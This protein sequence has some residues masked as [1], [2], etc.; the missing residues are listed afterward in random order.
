MKWPP[1]EIVFAALA[2]R[3]RR[4]G[5]GSHRLASCIVSHTCSCPIIRESE[6]IEL[7]LA[8]AL[9]I[10][11]GNEGLQ[12][13]TRK[14]CGALANQIFQP[15]PPRGAPETAVPTAIGI[16]LPRR[17]GLEARQH[18]YLWTRREVIAR[19]C[20]PARCVQYYLGHGY[21]NSRAVEPLSPADYPA[22]IALRRKPLR[23]Y[24]P[25]EAVQ[26]PPRLTV[27]RWPHF[28]A[29]LLREGQGAGRVR[30]PSPRLQSP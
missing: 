4:R 17:Q 6:L 18:G 21:R 13:R 11:S 23:K 15:V 29:S 28:A 10:V 20:S 12:S 7:G 9:G 25:R 30:R 19:E 5:T 26:L 8:P 27:E 16:A 1:P 22:R 2:A 3:V 24:P 14:F